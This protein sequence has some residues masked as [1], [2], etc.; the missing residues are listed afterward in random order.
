MA[1][2]SNMRFLRRSEVPVLIATLFLSLIFAVSSENFFSAY[3]MYNIMRTAAVYVLIALSQAMVMMVGGTSLCI[4]YIG[5]M[6]VVTAGYCMQNLGIGGIEATFLAVLVSMLCGAMNGVII[7]KLGLSA[8]V[9]TLSTQ[10]IFKGLVTGISKGFPYTVL[11]PNYTAFGRGSLLGIPYITL[12]VIGILMIVWYVFRFTTVGRR[13]L[14]T[15]G[16]EFAAKMAAVKTNQ[17]IFIANILSGVFA[18]IAAVCTVSM[19]GSGQPSTGADWMLYSFA[20]AVIGGTGLK[21]G[22]INPVGLAIA[23]FLIVIIKNGL[24][25]MDANVY[26]EQ[27]Y[28]GLILLVACSVGVISQ[29]ITAAKRRHQF[30]MEQLTKSKP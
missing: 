29:R 23:G 1:E 14:A 30:R 4:G 19:N 11:S 8:F 9:A 2:K 28:L 22:V 15:G 27:T 3:N 7:T 6:S 13:L 25:L 26:F 18:G 12:L 20:V 21:G 17:M 5:A 24:V 10:F 16:N